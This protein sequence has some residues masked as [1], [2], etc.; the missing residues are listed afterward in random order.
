MAARFR[1]SKG[2]LEASR[3]IGK[4]VVN[5]TKQSER[6]AQFCQSE[7]TV[8]LISEPLVLVLVLAVFLFGGGASGIFIVGPKRSSVSQRAACRQPKRPRK[9]VER[10]L[11]KSSPESRFLQPSKPIWPFPRGS[12]P[13]KSS[14][15][16]QNR[17]NHLR[18]NE[19]LWQSKR[20]GP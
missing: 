4:R 14:S 19:N 2:V 11:P 9:G 1:R 13:S 16:C 20:L 12:R 7:L 17:P 5:N 6:E 18:G 10:R 15:A 8:Q 3:A